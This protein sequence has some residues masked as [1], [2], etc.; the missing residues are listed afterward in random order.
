MTA[1][2][3][4]LQCRDGSYYVGCTTKSPEARLAEHNRGLLGGYTKARRPVRLVWSQE[5]A[6]FDEAGAFERQLKGWR[7]AKKEA[8]IRGDYASLR[9]LARNRQ[10][11][12]R[13]PSTGSGRRPVK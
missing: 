8:L 4:I 6:R 7:R 9:A 10:T 13:R 3:Y 5:F 1:H 2:V 11:A 12:P